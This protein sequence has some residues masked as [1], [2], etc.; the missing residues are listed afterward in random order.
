MIKA[1]MLLTRQKAKTMQIGRGQQSSSDSDAVVTMASDPSTIIM[2]FPPSAAC[3]CES[4][5]SW[6]LWLC[7][8]CS[9]GSSLSGFAFEVWLCCF[10]HP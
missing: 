2:A 1:L 8:T 3:C 7:E 10:Q 5:C 4:R 6:K 9:V